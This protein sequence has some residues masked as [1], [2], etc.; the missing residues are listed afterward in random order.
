MNTYA[1]VVYIHLYVALYGII[2][3][4]FFRF[5]SVCAPTTSTHR[6]YHI[7][8]LPPF[9]APP[10]PHTILAMRFFSQQHFC[11]YS[12]FSCFFFFLSFASSLI[13]PIYLS[14]VSFNIDTYSTIQFT[15]DPQIIWKTYSAN[16]IYAQY[17]FTAQSIAF[18]MVYGF[19][20]NPIE[21]N[22][23]QSTSI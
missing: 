2:K 8:P 6:L 15:C 11:Y 14:F 23:I 20:I 9:T 12:F 10:P 7:P 21:S 22:R 16:K 5:A 18:H 3:F 13:C 4:G 19:P 1:F 17:L